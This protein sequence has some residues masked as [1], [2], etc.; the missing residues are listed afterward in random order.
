MAALLKAGA[1][2]EAGPG[3]TALE[4]ALRWDRPAIAQLLLSAGAD[5]NR[6]SP[7]TD[8]SPLQTACLLPQ[9]LPLVR[10]L[11][12]VVKASLAEEYATVRWFFVAQKRCRTA[13]VVAKQWPLPDCKTESSLVESRNLAEQ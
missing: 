6:R 7:L 4:E 13:P 3:P 2:P 5:P 8:L 9:P 1:S 10:L 12:K 11:L